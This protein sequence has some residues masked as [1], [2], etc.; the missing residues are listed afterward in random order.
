MHRFALDAQVVERLAPV[1]HEFSHYSFVM[2]PRL[3]RA[4]QAPAVADV[5]G[6]EWLSADRID[7]G[8][9]AGADSSDAAG[10]DT[11]RVIT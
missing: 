9:A 10:P 7:E 5:A 3:L 2:H 1:R 6:V 4:T 8:R 11:C